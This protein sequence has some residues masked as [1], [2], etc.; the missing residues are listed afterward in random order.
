MAEAILASENSVWGYFHPPNLIMQLTFV[1]VEI[2]RR[3]VKISDL[4]IF[5]SQGGYTTHYFP[6]NSNTLDSA[7]YIGNIQVAT[8]VSP[9]GIAVP[10]IYFC[11]LIDLLK[12]DI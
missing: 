7:H 9:S 3:G 6:F 5:T 4:V 10:T 11:P 2:T 8:S 1:V 12:I